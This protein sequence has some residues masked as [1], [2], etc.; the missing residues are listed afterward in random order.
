MSVSP[1]DD[2]G[3][4]R[5]RMALLARLPVRR[6][7]TADAASGRTSDPELTPRQRQ[8]VD[9]LIRGL[10]NKEIAAELGVGPDAVKRTISRL[11]IKLNAPSRTAL[12]Q[13]ALRTSAARLGRSRGPNALSLLDAAPVP[14]L[15]T[16]GEQHLVE[17]VNPACQEVLSL[18][19]VGMRLTDVL[20]AD[21]RTTVALIA[22]AC[23][24]TRTPRAARSVLLTDAGGHDTTWR[25]ADVFAS[26]VHDGADQL[27]GLVVFLVDVTNC[28]P[29]P[30][31]SA[32]ALE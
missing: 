28:P 1:A 22:D 14:A 20:P 19:A 2:G 7:Q 29:P 15:V 32:Q 24:T 18:A 30:Q 25:R 13:V 8:V 23:F 3:I 9:G 12:V 11:L 17:Y 16:R 5:R 27:A 4:E 10:A 26:P 31:S 6:G 21:A